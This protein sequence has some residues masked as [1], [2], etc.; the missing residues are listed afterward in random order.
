MRGVIIWTFDSH[1]SISSKYLDKF[2]L[3]ELMKD[4]N[5]MFSGIERKGRITIKKIFCSYNCLMRSILRTHITSRFT[6]VNF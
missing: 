3:K 2:T 5:R 6:N 4:E 1:E